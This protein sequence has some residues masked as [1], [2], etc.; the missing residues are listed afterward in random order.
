MEVELR[1]RRLRFARGLL[2]GGAMLTRAVFGG[3]LDC[4]TEVRRTAWRK[5]VDED[6][7]EVRGVRDW[8][9]VAA[10]G[11]AVWHKA[12]AELREREPRVKRSTRVEEGGVKCTDCEVR[13]ETWGR[14]RA[15]AARTHGGMD[16][17]VR[18]LAEQQRCPFCHLCLR[19]ERRPRMHV[20][21]RSMADTLPCPGVYAPISSS[22]RQSMRS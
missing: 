3:R 5:L 8:A 7:G 13:F 22:A 4:E 12:T 11:K 2:T 6:L 10:M 17:V 16:A 18:F 9:E 14:M 19:G 21:R 15:H 20:T 1:V